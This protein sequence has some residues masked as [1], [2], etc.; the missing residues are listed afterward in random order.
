MVLSRK[1]SKVLLKFL[2]WH[3]CYNMTT[4]NFT[5]AKKFQVFSRSSVNCKN[6]TCNCRIYFFQNKSCHNLR[7][8]SCQIKRHVDAVQVLWIK[9]VA[10]DMS[11]AL[12]HPTKSTPKLSS[13]VA[14]PPLPIITRS[15]LVLFKKANVIFLSSLYA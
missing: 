13:R 7:S 3:T 9:K 5:V 12:I 8:K 2:E 14:A 11:S 10:Q 4:N 15:S 6:F 1:I